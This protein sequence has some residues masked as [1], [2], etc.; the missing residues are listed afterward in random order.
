REPRLGRVGVAPELEL[1]AI[2]ELHFPGEPRAEREA[3]DRAAERREQL[4]EARVA[5]REL[6]FGSGRAAEER[7]RDYGVGGEARS[8]LVHQAARRPACE[9]HV[10]L[11]AHFQ[12]IGP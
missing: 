8:L 7:Q 6:R 12:S 11:D 3:L 1:E 5:A 10:L 9:R 4:R 2:D